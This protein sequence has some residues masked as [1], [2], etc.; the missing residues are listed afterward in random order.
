MKAGVYYGA[1]D[2]RP[3]EIEIPKIGPDDILINV[4]A[5]GICGSDLHGYRQGHF[6]R[7]GWIMGHE[8]AG[9][10]AEAG[11]RVKGIKTGDRVVYIPGEHGRVSQGCGSCFWCLRGQHQWCE[12]PTTTRKPCGKCEYCVAGQ[13]WNCRETL[14]YQG[15][16]YSRNG[17]YS[18][19]AAIWDAVLNKNV[20]RLPNNMSYDEGAALEPLVGCIRWVAQAEPQPRDTAVVLGLGTIGLMAMQLL[21]N[22]VSRVIVSEVSQRRLEVARELGADAAIDAAKEDPV[23]KVAELTGVGRSRS[24]RGGGR[25]DFAM[26]CSGA[27]V[28]LQQAMQMTRAGGRVVLVGL[29]E[30]PATID[31]NLIIFKDLKL[32]SSQSDFAGNL[33]GNPILQAID[34]IA[35]GKVKVKPLISHAFPV[36]KIKEAFEVQTRA[37]ESVKVLIRP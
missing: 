35:G 27:G 28:A 33:T 4:K 12:A 17:G 32:I 1:R 37:D 6:T 29:F 8:F 21:K 7:P 19:Y 22:M 10:V 36:E 3:E 9:E 16:G 23:Q 2:I 18:E 20:Y 13:W 30:K 34:M 5:C 15:P 14:R 31:P 26:E 24:G 11:D 25:A